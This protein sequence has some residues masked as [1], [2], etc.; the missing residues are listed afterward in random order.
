MFLPLNLNDCTTECWTE[1][2]IFLFVVLCGQ[3]K[4]VFGQQTQENYQKYTLKNNLS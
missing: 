3:K 1:R 2:D 4:F